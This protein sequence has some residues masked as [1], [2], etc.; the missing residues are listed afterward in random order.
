MMHDILAVEPYKAYITE[1]CLKGAVEG[2]I[3]VALGP[4]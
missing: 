3:S 2:N 4:V 1:S